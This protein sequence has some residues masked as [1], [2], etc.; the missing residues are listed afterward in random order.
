LEQNRPKRIFLQSSVGE[1]H[2]ASNFMSSVEY[3]R[4]AAQCLWVAERI[5]DKQGKAS[6]MAMAQAWLALAHQAEKNVIV[7]TPT[8]PQRVAQQQQQPQSNPGKRE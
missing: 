4:N 8:P 2:V 7:Q 5:T 6:M 3:R 1:F